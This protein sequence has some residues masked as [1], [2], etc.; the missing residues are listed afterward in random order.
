[1]EEIRILNKKVDEQGRK[2]DKIYTAIAG[3]DELNIKGVRQHLTELDATVVSHGNKIKKLEE[4]NKKQKWVWRG[5]TVFLSGTAFT[6][7]AGG[8]KAALTKI[9]AGIAAAILVYLL[10]III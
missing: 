5:F 9:M 1:M 4:I 8:V 6:A 3:D 10:I 7:G 2:I